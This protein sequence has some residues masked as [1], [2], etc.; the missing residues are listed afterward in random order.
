MKWV[1]LGHYVNSFGRNLINK[2]ARYW[3]IQVLYI[4]IHTTFRTYG[5]DGRRVS[6]VTWDPSFT[7]PHFVPSKNLASLAMCC[8]C[9][10]IWRWLL[11]EIVVGVWCCWLY[12]MSNNLYYDPCV[13]GLFYKVL[14]FRK[15]FWCKIVNARL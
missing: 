14:L 1:S 13:R 5:L 10:Y 4:C 6:L 7:S 12:Y 9:L 15:T 11:E 2:R 8:F 3:L